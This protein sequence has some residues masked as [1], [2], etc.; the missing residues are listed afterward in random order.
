MSVSPND[1]KPAQ[2]GLNDPAPKR[3][4][5]PP[6]SKNKS[7]AGRPRKTLEVQIGAMLTTVNMIVWAIPPLQPDA[8]D[9]AEIAA[10]AKALDETARN[11]PKFRGYLEAALAVGS[12]GQLLGVVAMI[13]AR[14]ASRH[15]MLPP[16][17][18]GMIGSMLQATTHE[19]AEA[20]PLPNAQ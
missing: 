8:L 10:L 13:G 18:D 3:R 7:G 14:R 2:E 19:S 1:F 5:R 17:M 20:V 6:G 9:A 11:N 12:G 4:G 15:G 16:E